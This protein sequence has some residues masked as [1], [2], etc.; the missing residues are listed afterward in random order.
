[1]KVQAHLGP[2][3]HN[4]FPTP[5]TNR[6]SQTCPPSAH[7]LKVV[8]VELTANGH[9]SGKGKARSD[10]GNARWGADVR[11]SYQTLKS[12]LQGFALPI[13]V[14][15]YLLPLH[16]PARAQLAGR[17]TRMTSTYR[18]RRSIPASNGYRYP[19]DAKSSA[20]ASA[21]DR[22]DCELTDQLFPLTVPNQLPIHESYQVPTAMPC[23]AHRRFSTVRI[24][25]SEKCTYQSRNMISP[26]DDPPNSI[27]LR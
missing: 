7:R 6:S 22:H 21:H 18:L 2:R 12:E 20:L 8:R 14:A 27:R 25:L 3:L 1:M 19:F 11:I 26:N 4:A 24:R 13:S 10:L 15:S 9:R 16:L 17:N 5:T 23:C